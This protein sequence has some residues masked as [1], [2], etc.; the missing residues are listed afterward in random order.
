MQY[1][2]KDIGAWQARQESPFAEQNRRTAAEQ[3]AKQQAKLHFK[4]QF[5]KYLPTANY[6]IVGISTFLVLLFSTLWLVGV[7]IPTPEIA[8]DSTDDINNYVNALQEIYEDFNENP[9]IVKKAVGNTLRTENGKKYHDA[10]RLGQALFGQSNALYRDAVDAAKDVV[11]ADKLTLYERLRLY[12]VF[13]Y[14]GYYAGDKELSDIY[15][16]VVSELIY[17]LTDGGTTEP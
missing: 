8:G 17:E 7:F 12:N 3:A 9:K 16:P 4:E 5:E 10:T 14:S 6:V 1:L 13:Y 11:A 2:S 15:D